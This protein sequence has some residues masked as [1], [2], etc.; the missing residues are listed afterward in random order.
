[1]AREG[2][3]LA[4]VRRLAAELSF[5]E[6]LALPVA[7]L[8]VRLWTEG[9]PA[10]LRLDVIAALTADEPDE[11]ERARQ[12]LVSRR[13]LWSSTKTEHTLVGSAAVEE[14]DDLLDAEGEIF[15]EAA[16]IARP[17][18]DVTVPE[19]WNTPSSG[20]KRTGKDVLVGIVDTGI[21]VSHP[22]FLMPSG[23]TRVLRLWDQAT[24]GTASPPGWFSYGSEWDSTD[25]DSHVSTSPGTPFPSGDHDGH[26]TAVAGIAAGNGSAR[27]SGRYVGVAPEADL[28][29]VALDARRGAFPSTANVQEAV[30]YV[31]EVADE[32]KRRAV[33]NLSHGVQ[34]GPHE[35]AD[36]LE[37]GLA[38]LLTAD[39]RRILVIA[40]GNAADGN[41][42]ARVHVPVGRHTDIELDIPPLVGPSVL[43]DVWYDTADFLAAQ[44]LDPSGAASAVVEGNQSSA[45]AIGSGVYELDGIP[46]AGRVRANQVQVKLH[47][48]SYQGDVTPGRWT[49]RLHPRHMPSGTE[50]DV[51]L[52]PGGLPSPRFASHVVS[53]CTVTSP[54][55]AGEAIA[56]GAYRVTPTWA[57]WRRPRA[58]G[59]TVAARPSACSRH[60]ACR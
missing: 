24:R 50:A 6:V 21:D 60:P 32:L 28:V 1:M 15:L 19:A 46:N 48:P 59:R 41:A 35:P 27:P 9:D 36:L 44:V 55:T 57:P 56:V 8:P 40:A 14:L 38:D 29:V 51:W 7:P 3:L 34:I 42:H 45:G 43:A 30:R 33:V 54:A 49:L 16:P 25:I 13:G 31:F 10:D 26:G 17:A 23:A 11:R 39:D 4:S 2:P 53:D 47:T 37:T 18:L 58:A 5:E 12:A 52:D 22:D 20:P